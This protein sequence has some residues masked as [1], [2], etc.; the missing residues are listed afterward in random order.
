MGVVRRM[1]RVA[2]LQHAYAE[3]APRFGMPPA[4]QMRGEMVQEYQY[5]SI[6]YT[7]NPRASRKSIT[8]I[9]VQRKPS[10]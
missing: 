5:M 7:S 9:C 10:I 3:R 1:K 2:P 6:S 8:V 4:R